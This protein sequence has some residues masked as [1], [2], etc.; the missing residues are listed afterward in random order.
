MGQ[1]PPRAGS[2]AI[3]DKHL[4]DRFL[5]D[6]VITLP[7]LIPRADAERMAGR[8]W[9]ALEARYGTVRDRP[10]TWTGERAWKLGEVRKAGAFAPMFSE[11]LAAVL[12]E[13]FGEGRWTPPARPGQPLVTFPTPGAAW[14]VPH[15]SWHLDMPPGTQLAPWP[16]HVR[17]FTFLADLEP[18]GGGTVYVA[19]SHRPAMAA[20]AAMRGERVATSA[21]VAVA[22]RAASPWVADLCAPGDPA[23]RVRRFMREG[24]ML[25][26]V[27]LK[28]GEMTGA[29]GDVVLMH[30]GVLHAGAPNAWTTPRLMLTETVYGTG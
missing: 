13:F 16:D 14:T 5:A 26:G 19:G 15:Q 8:L 12:D 4:R 2:G 25:D 1:S 29:A 22:L 9:A 28:V 23:A 7:G 11:G 18:G 30:P 17:I 6:G 21:A 24:G 10:E 20:L 3:L 27:P